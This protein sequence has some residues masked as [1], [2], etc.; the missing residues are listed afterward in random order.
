MAK[1]IRDLNNGNNEVVNHNVV[2]EDV[3]E[4]VEVHVDLEEEE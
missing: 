3:V 2:V 4:D 1:W